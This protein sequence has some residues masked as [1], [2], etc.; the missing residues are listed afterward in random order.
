[1][2]RF[3]KKNWMFKYV[4]Y[5]DIALT[6]DGKI[7]YEICS[8]TDKN[9]YSYAQSRHMMKSLKYVRRNH[10]KFYIRSYRCHCCGFWHLT[11]EKPCLYRENKK[12][13]KYK[14]FQNNVA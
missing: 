6:N 2:S 5:E 9:C 8:H 10:N 12:I 13:W 4:D 1:M 7:S 14:R 11:S 3:E